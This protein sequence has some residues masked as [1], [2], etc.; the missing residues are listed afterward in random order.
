MINMSVA[1]TLLVFSSI[2]VSSTQLMVAILQ[3]V[4]RF[5]LTVYVLC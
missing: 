4:M 2:P 3:S 1:A 5:S